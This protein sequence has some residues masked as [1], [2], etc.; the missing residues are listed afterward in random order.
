MRPDAAVARALLVAAAVLAAATGAWAQPQPAGI[1]AC[2]VC[3]GAGGNSPS[4]AIPSIAGQ[5]RQFIENQLVLIREG[6]R[7]VPAMKAVMG[8]MND[9]E[10]VALA[11]HFAAQPALP[12]PGPVDAAKYAAGAAVSA[13]ALCG[14][15]H[16]P[17]YVG[18]Q[19]VPRLARQHELY[20]A[21][22]M[23]MY[24]DA[25]APGRDTAMSAALYGLKD[26]E[27]EALAH[28]LAHQGK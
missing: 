3:H 13:R 26:G 8:G 12:P 6:L 20:L 28:Y 2:T 16:L 7:D 23:K 19:Q 15:C 22:T 9:A 21:V 4:P 18:Q 14:T 1:E 25:P 10:I 11:T 24:R 17:G 27:L 5:P